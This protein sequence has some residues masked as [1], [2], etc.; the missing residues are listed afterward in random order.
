MMI[1]K[2]IALVIVLLA[3]AS[4]LLLDYFNKQELISAEQMRQGVTQARVEAQKRSEEELRVKAQAKAY[5]EKQLS[6]NLASCQETANK[7]QQHYMGLIQQVVPRKAGKPVITKA[8]ADEA[9]NIIV[10]AKAECQQVYDARL[11]SGQ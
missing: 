2:I 3:S 6:V 9:E 7:A 5:F 1:K 8:V 10:N 4:W 11:K